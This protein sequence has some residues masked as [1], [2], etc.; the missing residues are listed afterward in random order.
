MRRSSLLPRKYRISFQPSSNASFDWRGCDFVVGC[1]RV[2]CDAGAGDRERHGAVAV[3]LRAQRRGMIGRDQD[4]LVALRLQGL[5]QRA[6]D[7]PVDFLERLDLGR[8]VALVRGFVGG[9]D[10]DAD[11]CRSLAARRSRSGP[12]RRSRCR[13][14]RSR[15]ALRSALQPISAARPRS[16][17]TAVIIA[18]RLPYSSANGSAAAC[19]PGPTARRSWPAACLLRGGR[20]SP[21][22]R[23]TAPTLSL[24]KSVQQ[25]AARPARIVVEHRLV[26]EVVRR[27]GPRVVRERAPAASPRDRSADCDS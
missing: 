22:G 6:D 14:S 1:C 7:V 10:V 19:G 16:R 20:R 4:A 3:G 8:R 26:G 13:D 2:G 18:P 17:S 9:F 5:V 21:D 23:Q 27:R 15:R 25:I 12:W 24:I 11:Q